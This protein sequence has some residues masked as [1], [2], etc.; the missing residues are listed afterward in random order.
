MEE[1]KRIVFTVINDLVHDQRM[2]RIC[3][4]LANAGFK[5]LL[6]GRVLP[7]S[8]P[9]ETTSFQQKRL[10]CFFNKG[11][12]FYIEYNLR[13]FF[14]LI[15]QRADILAPADADTLVPS[16]LVSRIRSQKIVY[17]AHEYFSEVPEV[18]RRKVVQQIWQWVE[19]TFYP[20]I[21]TKYTVS[22]TLAAEMG[23]RYGTSFSTIRNVPLLNEQ[24]TMVTAGEKFILYQ[25]AL[26]EGR[27]LEE[28]IAAMPQLPVKLKLAGE[29]DLS[30]A[31]REQVKQ[32]QLT[33]K[34]EFLGYVNPQQLKQF[35]QQAFLGYNLLHHA[36]QSYY[37][38]LSNKFFDYMHA[39]VPSLNPPFP[40]YK[41]ILNHYA[42]G[43]ICEAT[44]ASIIACISRLLDDEAF[45][46]TLR[47]QCWQARQVYN[48]QHEEKALIQLY[49]NC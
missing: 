11:K 8:K 17:D 43:V 40:E 30:G 4:S 32:L 18:A 21:K 44:T 39:G 15:F 49:E 23:R 26:N 33:D 6:V 2:Q 35:T 10:S 5:V 38:S 12:L 29:G 25:G 46:V 19:R 37:Y 31:L 14:F 28:L 16:F 20:R 41:A 27:A 3:S 22:E 24:E 42:T 45:Y 7:A 13:L 9:L 36:G 47:Q 1:K 48:W 34:V